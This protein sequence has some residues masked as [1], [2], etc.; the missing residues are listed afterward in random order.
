MKKFEVCFEFPDDPEWR[1]LLPELLGK[2]EPP[3][4]GEFDPAECLNFEYDYN[5]LPEGLLPRFIVRTHHSVKARRAGARGW[6]WSSKAIV[7]W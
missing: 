2:E 3:V 4:A 7:R 6:S 5:I 1:Y